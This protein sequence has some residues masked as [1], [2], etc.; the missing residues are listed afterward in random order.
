ME[1]LRQKEANE[2]ALQAIGNPR[3][4]LKVGLNSS[5]NMSSSILNNSLNSSHFGLSSKPVRIYC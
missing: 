1:E 3:K 2:T 4:K 5:V